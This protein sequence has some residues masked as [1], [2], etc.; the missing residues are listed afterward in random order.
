MTDT[1]R[2]TDALASDWMVGVLLVVF[3]CLAFASMASPRKLGLLFSSFFA[4]R[5]GKQTLRDELDLRDRTLVVLFIA[6]AMLIALF[7]YQLT[8][9]GGGVEPGF[10]YYLEVLGLVA[11]GLLV[12][13][14]VLQCISLLA[15]T[16]EGIGEYFHTVVLFNIMMGLVLLP[17]TMLMAYPY[18]IP[19]RDWVWP[20]GLLAVLLLLLFR[21]GRA[22]VIGV[23]EGVPLRYIF[24]YLCGAEIVPVALF[25]QQL[26]HLLPALA[27]PL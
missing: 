8:L 23:A 22:L 9:Y 2:A 26:R 25:Y 12:P 17:A 24:L 15:G 14:L 18:A 7:G 10:L 21:W 6:G 16:E 11:G 3:G 5:L 4:L 27:H 1:L 13:L 20:I 19:W